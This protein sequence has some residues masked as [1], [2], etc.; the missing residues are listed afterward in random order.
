MAD[1]DGVRERIIEAAT[2]RFSHYGYGKT[3][4]AEIA[5]DCAMSPGNIYRYFPGKLDLAEVIAERAVE[6][7][8]VQLRHEAR[9]P[10]RTATAR[11][12]AVL[13]AELHLTHELIRAMPTVAEFVTNIWQQRPAVANRNLAAVRGVLIEVLAIGNANGEFA[14]ED[15][16]HAAEMIQCATLKYRYPQMWSRLDLADL[17]RELDGVLDLLLWG[18]A[19]GARPSDR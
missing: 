11:L 6:E 3:T 7:I 2:A 16:M 10:G 9:H 12:R 17:E 15:V 14:I 13:T 8:V 5:G 4:M 18:I 1:K 19:D